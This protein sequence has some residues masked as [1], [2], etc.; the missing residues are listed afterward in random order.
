MKKFFDKWVAQSYRNQVLT[1]AVLFVLLVIAGGIVGLFVLDMSNAENAKFGYSGTWGIMQCVDG[2]FV[3]ATITNNEKLP[4]WIVVFVSLFFWLGG[5]ILVSFFTGAATDFLTSRREDIL[6]GKVDYVFDKDYILI[7]GIDF[8]V[9]NLIRQLLEESSSN[10][11][12]ITDS[13]VEDFWEEILPELKK[14]KSYVRRLFIMRKEIAQEESYKNIMISQAKEIYLIGDE[15]ASGR[16]G[17]TLLALE[18]MANKAVSEMD[19]DNKA[20][21]KPIKVYMHIADSELYYQIRTMELPAEGK[22]TKAG[23][24]PFDLE[25]FNYYESWAWKCWSEKGSDDGTKLPSRKKEDLKKVLEYFDDDVRSRFAELEMTMDANT[26]ICR[27]EE[28]LVAYLPIRHMKGSK[29]TELFIIGAGEMGGTLCNFAM[30][31]MNYGEDGK[32]SRITLFDPDG[33]KQSVLP[34][35]EI[36]DA[37]PEVDVRFENIDGCSDEAND[38]ML[39]AANR[40]DTSVTVVVALADPEAAMRA[41]RKLSF[42]L[43]RKQISIL[44]WQAVKSNELL[45]KDYLRMGGKG[46]KAE[47]AQTRYFGMTDQ[48]PWRNTDRTRSGMAVNFYYNTWF[49]YGQ[50]QPKSPEATA[51]DFVETSMGQWNKLEGEKQWSGVSR[52]KKWSSVNTGDTFREKTV[53]LSEGL[54]YAQTAEKILKAEHNRW[55]TER[56]LSGWIQDNQLSNKAGSHADKN[57]LLHGDMIPFEQLTDEEKGKDKICIASMYALEYVSK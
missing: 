13:S 2:G 27:L 55:W 7:I 16:D 36:I 18:S 15:D 3:D 56:L 54:P 35:R 12:V 34:K 5:M 28:M 29:D 57:H 32:H 48:L 14:N 23:K 25:I 43:R 45:E 37:L 10:I 6:A 53:L 31:L 1:L 4:T 11:V 19:A 17:K 47:M 21:A 44:V 52:W 20:E 8:Q 41:F 50:E 30:P 22:T 9:E 38:I 39:E 26:Y 24:H 49:P 33:L 51:D 46:N 40:P 42:Q